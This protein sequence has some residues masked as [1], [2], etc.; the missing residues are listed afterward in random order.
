MSKQSNIVLELSRA[1]KGAYVRAARPET[2]A[3]WIFKHLDAAS[4]YDAEAERCPGCGM[5]VENCQGLS[6]DCRRKKQCCERDHDH[7]GNC[8]RHP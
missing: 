1:R 4:G 8:D 7:D 6:P 2:L 3:G 5:H